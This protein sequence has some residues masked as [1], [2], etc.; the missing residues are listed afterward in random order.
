MHKNTQ[1]KLAGE[2][3][4]EGCFV[5]AL[6]AF[7]PP[8]EMQKIKKKELKEKTTQSLLLTSFKI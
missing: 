7:A 3:F 5:L 2:W 6:Y 8:I 4:K 1:G